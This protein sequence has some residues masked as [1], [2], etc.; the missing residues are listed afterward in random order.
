MFTDKEAATLRARLLVAMSTGEAKDILDFPPHANPSP[1]EV[2]KRLR[3][4]VKE[5]RV[6]PDQ[7]GGA[8]SPKMVELSVAA[9]ILQGRRI[10]DLTEVQPEDEELRKRREAAQRIKT[11]QDK[12]TNGMKLIQNA[13][14]LQLRFPGRI[15]LRDYLVDDFVDGLGDLQDAADEALEGELEPRDERVWKEVSKLSHDLVGRT[16]RLASKY[17]ALLKDVESFQK[18][19]KLADLK[20]LMK[21]AEKYREMFLDFRMAASRVSGLLGTTETVPMDAYDAY[22]DKFNI[23]D[24]FST[25]FKQINFD[26]RRS[27]DM[28]L[29]AIEAAKAEAD[30]FKVQTPKPEQWVVPDDFD[31]LVSTLTGYKAASSRMVAAHFLR[32]I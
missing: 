20:A 2:R 31:K 13:Y 23:I 6:H 9:D 15:S 29:E 19:P 1:E 17:K 7:G 18:S 3:T 11:L 26:V 14:V 24:A 4:K 8:H 16:S 10:N 28:V 22:F 12:A 25:Q 5:L 32:N 21:Q 27:G 30:E